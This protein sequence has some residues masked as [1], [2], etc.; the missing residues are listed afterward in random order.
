MEKALTHTQHGR[1]D[2]AESTSADEGG[3][4][5]AGTPRQFTALTFGAK[6]LTIVLLL[7]GIALTAYAL[8]G[9]ERG[10]DAFT[11]TLAWAQSVLIAGVVVGVGGILLRRFHARGLPPHESDQA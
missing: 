1:V 10:S 4:T 6:A 2:V 11:A 7:T 3:H 8:V 5:I 9:L